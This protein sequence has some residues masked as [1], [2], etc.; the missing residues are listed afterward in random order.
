[1]ERRASAQLRGAADPLP[2]VR[3]LGWGRFSEQVLTAIEGSLQLN[4]TERPQACSEVL[5]AL[6]ESA[7]PQI[8]ESP[9][10]QRAVPLGQSKQGSKVS[11][12]V[13]FAVLVVM[14]I[15]GLAVLPVFPPPLV[16]ESGN[17]R[18]VF[19]L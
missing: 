17:E 15:L 12:G 13:V 11:R 6:R 2:S 9:T 7:Q 19:S 4:A 1:M 14:A 16:D 3:R 10:T 8:H 18:A 5:G